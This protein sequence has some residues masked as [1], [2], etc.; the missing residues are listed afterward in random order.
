[1]TLTEGMTDYVIRIKL[2]IDISTVDKV[3]EEFT[4]DAALDN[5]ERST[6]TT[7]ANHVRQMIIH[8]ENEL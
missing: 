4:V 6:L 2:A 7:Y 3:I 1:M 5:I 8:F